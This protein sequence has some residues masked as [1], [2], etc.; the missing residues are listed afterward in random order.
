[1]HEQ[2]Q[3]IL[4]LKEQKVNLHDKQYQADIKKQ[5]DTV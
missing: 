3:K 5:I 4:G 2:Y 1:L